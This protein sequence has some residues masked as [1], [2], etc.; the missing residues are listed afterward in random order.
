MPVHSVLLLLG[1]TGKQCSIF[2]VAVWEVLGSFFLSFEGE[3]L[4]MTVLLQCHLIFLCY[5][6]FFFDNQ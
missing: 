2:E 6:P 1:C 4:S 3:D 5:K